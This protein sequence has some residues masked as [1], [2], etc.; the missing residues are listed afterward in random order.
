MDF[1][2]LVLQEIEECI[3]QVSDFFGYINGELEHCLTKI[4][5]EVSNQ[6]NLTIDIETKT[7]KETE[8]KILAKLSLIHMLHCQLKS[9]I[10]VKG[11]L[12]LNIDTIK[13]EYY[14]DCFVIST[15]NFKFLE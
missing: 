13:G 12:N 10:V 14:F 7:L 1:I 9:L 4:N 11:F 3:G 6:F 8:D 5:D 15:L 2:S